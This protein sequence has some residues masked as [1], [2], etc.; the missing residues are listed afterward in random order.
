[1]LVL[2][3]VLFIVKEMVKLVHYLLE[4]QVFEVNTLVLK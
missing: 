1:M 2:Y 3:I 4:C